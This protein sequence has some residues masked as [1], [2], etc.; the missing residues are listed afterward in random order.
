MEVNYT[1]STKTSDKIIKNLQ[2]AGHNLSNKDRQM[3]IDLVYT[4]LRNVMLWEDNSCNCGQPSCS[5]CN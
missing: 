2:T 4:A 5:L 3:I 1:N